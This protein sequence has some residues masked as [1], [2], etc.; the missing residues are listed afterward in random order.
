MNE[1][2]AIGSLIFSKWIEKFIQQERNKGNFGAKEAKIYHNM[3][4][5]V[6]RHNFL[7]IE[8]IL[9]FNFF[10]SFEYTLLIYY[11]Y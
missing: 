8:F 5:Q 9:Y 3:I 10:N 6:H 1:D 11:F 4:V 2:F 7:H